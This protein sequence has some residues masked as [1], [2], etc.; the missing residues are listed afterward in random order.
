MVLVARLSGTDAML[1]PQG[2][3]TPL[4]RKGFTVS[5]V[6]A[7]GLA[8]LGFRFAGTALLPAC[9]WFAVTAVPLMLIDWVCHRLPSRLVAA[10]FVGGLVNFAY[11]AITHDEM[12]TMLRAVMAAVA[13][14]GAA[15]ATAVAA[16]GSLGGGDVKLLG[17]VALYLGWAGWTHLVRGVVLAV[18]LAATVCLFL[19]LL[20]RLAWGDR[21]AFGPAIVGGALIALVLP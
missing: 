3:S 7:A 13:V 19:I 18:V 21:F 5:T 20:R 1:L 9:M 2:W 11:L 4:T 14:F 10:M 12:T 17:T 16:P 8:V 15:L 6:F